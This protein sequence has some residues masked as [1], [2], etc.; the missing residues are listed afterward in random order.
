MSWNWL[1]VVVFYESAISYN[2]FCQTVTGT[3]EYLSWIIMFK[4]SFFTY[5]YSRCGRPIKASSLIT[6]KEFD[7]NNLPRK[8]T[9]W[10]WWNW[11]I[12]NLGC[13]Y[14]SEKWVGVV[15]RKMS[16]WLSATVLVMQII[17]AAFF[18]LLIISSSKAHQGVPGAPLLTMT[19]TC[20]GWYFE[21]QSEQPKQHFTYFHDKG[22]NNLF[23]L[24]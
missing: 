9:Q 5:K 17:Y 11:Q 21:I 14:L 1:D 22:T 16:A 15:Y 24:F 12:V 7:V 6:S 23:Y 4:K 3:W 19:A 20:P 10:K 18:L 2:I 8:S 13:F